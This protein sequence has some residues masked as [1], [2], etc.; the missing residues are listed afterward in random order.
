MVAEVA[1]LTRDRWMAGAF[2]LGSACFLVA[3]FPGYARLVGG[4]AVALTFFVGSL[5][6]TTGGFLQVASA[7]PGRRDHRTG[8]AAWRSAIIQSV[9]TLF[10]NVSTWRAVTVAVSDPSYDRLVWRPD[11]LGSLCF[12]ASGVIAY[13]ASAR[14]GWRPSRQPRGWWQPAVNLLGCVFFG[15]AA[16]AGYVVPANGSELDL[17]AANLNTCLGAACFLVCAIWTW[18]ASGPTRAIEPASQPSG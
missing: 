16:V 11:A 2:G 9:G 15:I 4:L 3:P 1:H 7:A 17:A 8:A 10:F 6:F 14:V 18:R 5:L 13:R 12:L